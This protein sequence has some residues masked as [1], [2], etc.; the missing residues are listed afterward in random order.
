MFVGKPF[1]NSEES[2]QATE[3][4]LSSDEIKFMGPKSPAET[5]S[6]FYLDEFNYLKLAYES[7]ATKH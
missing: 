5:P 2:M 7:S 1:T 3:K 6:L 4:V